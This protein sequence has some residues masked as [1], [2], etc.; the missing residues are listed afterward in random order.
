MSLGKTGPLTQENAT[1]LDKSSTLND[2]I[3]AHLA[4]ITE[5]PLSDVA[6]VLSSS[7]YFSPFFDISSRDRANGVT[8]ADS[9]SKLLAQCKKLGYEKYFILYKLAKLIVFV[10]RKAQSTSY[11]EKISST[12]SDFVNNIGKDL[13]FSPTLIAYVMN[14]FADHFLE[15]AEVRSKVI[16]ALTKFTNTED[17]DSKKV[18]FFKLAAQEPYILEALFKFTAQI[19]AI[20]KDDEFI[21]FEGEL[22]AVSGT[23]DIIKNILVIIVQSVGLA[24]RMYQ[25]MIAE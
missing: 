24:K 2:L 14:L 19:T 17:I 23:Q 7:D 1:A 8:F 11:S 13:Q 6:D 5:I 25:N 22:N 20:A 21:N 12:S 9:Q 15:D 4:T 18:L 3:K 10:K 16:T